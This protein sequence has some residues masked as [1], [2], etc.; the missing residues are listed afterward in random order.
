MRMDEYTDKPTEEYIFKTTDRQTALMYMKSLD[1]QILIFD[2]KEYLRAKRKYHDDNSGLDYKTLDIICD[3]I[4]EKINE[5]G[6][7]DILK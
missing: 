1:A 6:L 2:I 5:S 7:N 3:E 4:L